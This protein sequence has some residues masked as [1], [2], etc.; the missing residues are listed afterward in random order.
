MRNRKESKLSEKIQKK[1]VTLREK[2]GNLAQS[3]QLESS[4]HQDIIVLARNSWESRKGCS[5]EKKSLATNEAEEKCMRAYDCK[6]EHNLKG[7]VQAKQVAFSVCLKRGNEVVI[8]SKANGFKK[9]EITK[10]RGNWRRLPAYDQCWEA[11]N[12]LYVF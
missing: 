6:K 7:H 9:G 3:N 11:K 5:W 8:R 2:L 4:L 10:R 1:R 12:L